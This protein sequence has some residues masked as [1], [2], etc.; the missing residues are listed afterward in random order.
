MVQNVSVC[1]RIQGLGAEIVN[2]LI[3][4]KKKQFGN[5]MSEF[6]EI[7]ELTFAPVFMPVTLRTWLER[8]KALFPWT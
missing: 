6:G 4:N 1:P 5:I 2:L 8:T 7:V 3:Q